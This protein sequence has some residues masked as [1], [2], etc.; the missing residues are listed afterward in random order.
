[1]SSNENRHPQLRMWLAGI[2]VLVAGGYWFRVS[3][4]STD[5][6]PTSSLQTVPVAKERF[7][8]KVLAEGEIRTWQP[9]ILYNDCRNVEREIL[10]IVPE[11]SWVEKGDVVCVLDC[12]ELERKRDQQRIELSKAQA[13]LAD[14]LSREELQAAHNRRR[15][16]TNR[17][18]AEMAQAD[19]AAYLHQQAPS[20]REQLSQ[21]LQIKRDELAEASNSLSRTSR[22]VAMGYQSMTSLQID[23]SAFLTQHRRVKLAEG[24]LGLLEQFQHPRAMIKLEGE[25]EDRKRHLDRTHLESQLASSVMEITALNM[26]QWEAGVKTYLAYLD[27]AVAACT[28]VAPK[29]GEIV[30]CHKRNEGKF[31]EAGQKVHYMQDLV[32]I[33]NRE[34]L[35]VAGRVSDADVYKVS[36]DDRVEVFVP[37]LP[38]VV[39]TGKL[40]WIAPIPT[41]AEWYQAQSLHHKIQIELDSDQAGLADLALSTTVKAT[42]VVD[43]RSSVLQVPIKSVFCFEKSSAVLVKQGDRIILC[44]IEVG[45]KNNTH[46]EVLEGVQEGWEV[47]IGDRQKLR[48]LARTL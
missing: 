36:E 17:L 37:T 7:T 3:E 15:V 41:S 28:M 43:D 26:R 48:T 32:R 42:I 5:Q 39:L 27:R 2:A 1:M 11:G 38:D 14:A 45:P 13:R 10:E 12:T 33:A 4:H 18:R 29:A 6:I 47:V 24:E 31:I 20:R 35:T 30:Y 25:A 19:L 34:R 8:R 23:K 44:R 9:A 22:M 21:Q 40:N 16:E 46:V